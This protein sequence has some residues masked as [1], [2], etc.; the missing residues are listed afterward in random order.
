MF[1]EADIIDYNFTKAFSLINLPILLTNNKLVL[2]VN[3]C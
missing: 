1:Y 3:A 2:A